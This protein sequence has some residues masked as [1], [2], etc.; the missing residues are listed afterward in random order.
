MN[1][2][3]LY[4]GSDLIGLLTNPSQE[5][6]Q[7]NAD[8]ELTAAADKHKEVLDYIMGPKDSTQDPPLSL[9]LWEDWVIEDEEGV[10]WGIC[11]PAIYPGAKYISWRRRRS[12]MR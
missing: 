4:R 10:I 11:P 7:F 1:P 12:L 5:G 9:N 8:L 2:L 6:P 3:K